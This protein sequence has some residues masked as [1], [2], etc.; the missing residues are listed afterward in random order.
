M[1]REYPPVLR[2]AGIGCH[3][4]VYLQNFRVESSSG[5]QA[6]DDAALRVARV[7]RFSAARNRDEKV[8]AWV[9]FRITFQV[10]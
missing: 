1:E 10:R 5:H 4:G 2:E 6:L 9:Q 3:V 8:P 7:Y